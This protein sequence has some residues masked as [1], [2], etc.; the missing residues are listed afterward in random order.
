MPTLTT[1]VRAYPRLLLPGIMSQITETEFGDPRIR[2]GE[3]G[4]AKVSAPWIGTPQ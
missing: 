2:I 1:L 3:P 4:N